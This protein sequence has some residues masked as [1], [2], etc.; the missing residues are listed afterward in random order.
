MTKTLGGKNENTPIPPPTRNQSMGTKKFRENLQ[1]SRKNKIRGRAPRAIYLITEE[2]VIIK[3]N[4]RSRIA[5]K[6]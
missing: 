6:D 4:L 2:I 3:S 1:N 5:S